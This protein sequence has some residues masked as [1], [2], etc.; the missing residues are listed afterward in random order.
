MVLA[1]PRLGSLTRN[2]D[3]SQRQNIF[4][5]SNCDDLWKLSSKINGA[6]VFFFFNKFDMV[7]QIARRVS[8]YE[9]RAL[10]CNPLGSHSS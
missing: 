7:S 1:L 8:Q 10:S 3:V 4:V 5:R 2:L 9:L 6:R